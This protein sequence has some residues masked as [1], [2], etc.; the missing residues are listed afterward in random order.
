MS[1]ETTLSIIGKYGDFMYNY[2]ESMP[3][4]LKIPVLIFGFLV[5]W[6]LITII[7]TGGF[8]NEENRRLI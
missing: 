6:N 3:L 4:Y 5:F 7:R 8:S 1:F 2:I